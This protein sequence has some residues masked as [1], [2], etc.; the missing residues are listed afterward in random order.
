MKKSSLKFVFLLLVFF[1]GLVF[2]GCKQKKSVSLKD[3]DSL[4]LSPNIQWAVVTSPYVAFRTEPGYDQLVAKHGRRG[5]ILEVLGKQ[6]IREEKIEDEN[7][8]RPKKI[9]TYATWY[10]FTDGWLEETDVSIY[11]NRLRAQSVASSLN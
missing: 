4:S 5:A 10:L 7:A 3:V 1:T 8:R 9:V 11:D 6:Y 2:S